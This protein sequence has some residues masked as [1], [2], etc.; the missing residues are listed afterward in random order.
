VSHCL[1]STCIRELEEKIAH[2]LTL[3]EKYKP[4]VQESSHPYQGVPGVKLS[5]SVK[6]PDA[7][8]LLVEFNEQCQTETGHDVLTFFDH[9]G[10]TLAVRT[11]HL[12]TDW[13]T[14]LKVTGEELNWSF[15][16]NSPGGLWGFKFIVIPVPPADD[17]EA[18]M[19]SDN[20]VL[21][22]SCMELVKRLLRMSFILLIL[23][24]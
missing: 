21:Q 16:T 3:Q 18:S 8:M 23:K 15:T 17:K 4:C 12:P 6:F 10:R 20:A 13:N 19:L 11:G 24:N 7:A 22:S 1:V 14:K 2:N 9:A 5:G